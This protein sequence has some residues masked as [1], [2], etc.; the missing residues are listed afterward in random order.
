MDEKV[1]DLQKENTPL[2]DNGENQV[3]D[4]TENLEK[5]VQELNQRLMRIAADFDNYRKR[6]R[7]EKEEF[8]KYANSNL[9]SDL[10]PVLDNF[11]RALDIKEPNE[12]VK[13]FLAGMEMIYRQL[14]QILEQAGLV[15][16]NA[17]GETFDPQ[18][19]EAVMQVEDSSAPDNSILE[20]LR[21]GYMYKDK[22]IR[23]SMVKV[24][25]NEAKSSDS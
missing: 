4:P 12:E 3:E 20:D 6:T 23:P 17:L 13:K 16:I 9:I 22:V 19:H 10:L 15:P 11:Q 7:M 14:M 24:A 2:E 8:M 5:E 18:K 21:C 25:K 1:E